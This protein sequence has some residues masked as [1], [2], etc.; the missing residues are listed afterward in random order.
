MFVKFSVKRFLFHS[1]RCK[2]FA[3]SGT[4]FLDDIFGCLFKENPIMIGF[5]IAAKLFSVFMIGTV[6]F[7]YSILIYTPLMML[8][9]FMTPE[10]TEF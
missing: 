7:E 10:T 9:F 5:R 8:R 6:F 4:I 2:F 3:A 1:L